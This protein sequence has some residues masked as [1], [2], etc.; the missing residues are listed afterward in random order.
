MSEDQEQGNEMQKMMEMLKQQLGSMSEGR[1]GRRHS[2]D[3]KITSISVPV[4]V[5]DRRETCR[6]YVNCETK[7]KSME[8]LAATLFDLEEMGIEPDWWQDSS[9]FRRG[10]GK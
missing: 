10:R 3:L 6:C 8:D 9:S 1:G 5:K 2:T 4:K 7:I